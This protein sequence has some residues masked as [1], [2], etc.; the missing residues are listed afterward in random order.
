MLSGCGIFCEEASRHVDDDFAEYEED[1]FDEVEGFDGAGR[2]EYMFVSNDE[3]GEAKEEPRAAPAAD[4]WLALPGG[5]RRAA[6]AVASEAER[7]GLGRPNLLCALRWARNHGLDASRAAAAYGDH[8]AWRKAEAVDGLEREHASLPPMRRRTLERLYFYDPPHSEQL[9]DRKGRPIKVFATA[10]LDKAGMRAADVDTA[11]LARYH[12]LHM[13]RLRRGREDRR[14]VLGDP[15]LGILEIFDVKDA[16]ISLFRRS[17]DE[18][19][20]CARINESRYPGL[21][22]ITL[23]VNAPSTF[24][25]CYAFVRPFLSYETQRRIGV[26]PATAAASRA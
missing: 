25:Y 16:T 22:G 7:R 9:H 13:E 15:S 3:P 23:I 18:I 10:R 1:T 12:L 24:G 11:A 5:D 2:F 21:V 26:V 14:P 8:C 4:E 20:A 6:S 19:I 17:F